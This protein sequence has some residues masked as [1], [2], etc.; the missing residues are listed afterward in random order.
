M[1]ISVL[2]TLYSVKSVLRS[3]DTFC[4]SIRGVATPLIEVMRLW[5]GD[6]TLMQEALRL[7]SYLGDYPPMQVHVRDSKVP[8]RAW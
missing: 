7:L 1:S 4:H 2:L 6:P 8:P 5:Q 3:I